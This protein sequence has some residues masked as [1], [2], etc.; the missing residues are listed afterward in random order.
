MLAYREL[1]DDELFEITEVR[2]RLRPEDLPGYKGARVACSEC[3]ESRLVTR[4]PC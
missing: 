1:S 2:V 3:G 4:S